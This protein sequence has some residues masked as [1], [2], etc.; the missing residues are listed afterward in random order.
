MCGALV[1][2]L[3]PALPAFALCHIITFEGDPYTVGEAAGVVTITVSN[4]GGQGTNQTVDYRTV[5]G[6]A[7]AGSDYESK[8]GT[9]TFPGPPGDVSFEVAIKNDSADEPAERFTVELS[10]LGGI[11]PQGAGLSESSAT[12]TINDNDPKPIAQPTQTQASSPKPKASSPKPSSPSPTPTAT[13]VSPSP[14][15][16]ATL[17]SPS[18]SP[19]TTVLATEAEDDGGLSG[20]AIGGIVAAVVIVGGGAAL[21]IRRRFLT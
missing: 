17:T 9:L 20:G 19:T 21:W 18:P 12:V 7:R 11:C 1:A 8:S 16:T 6:T 13:T 3:V 10:N 15:P 2:A 5:D 4:N 14:A